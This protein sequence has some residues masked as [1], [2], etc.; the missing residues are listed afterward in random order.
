MDR[1]LEEADRALQTL[2]AGLQGQ[3]LET[4]IRNAFD[5]ADPLGGKL[6]R[7]LALPCRSP[8]ACLPRGLF[9]CFPNTNTVFASGQ[10]FCLTGLCVQVKIR[11]SPVCDGG[12][13]FERRDDKIV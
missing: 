7:S 3:E 9:Q 4:A 8:I 1:I 6:D 13:T 10:C 11:E 12:A 5:S 2:F